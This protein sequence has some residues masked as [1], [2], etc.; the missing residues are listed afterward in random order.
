MYVGSHEKLRG[1]NDSLVVSG[2]YVLRHHVT[3]LLTLF[4]YTCLIYISKEILV[5]AI[6]RCLVHVSYL[7]GTRNVY[8]ARLS[9]LYDIIASL[10]RSIR[11]LTTFCYTELT[12]RI[13]SLIWSWVLARA[14][15]NDLTSLPQLRAFA[16]EIG[17]HAQMKT[18]KSTG[19]N[20]SRRVDYRNVLIRSVQSI[21]LCS[22]YGMRIVCR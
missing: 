22:T 13:S 5:G 4:T 21:S 20:L 8:E 14:N 12:R 15:I 18:H 10:Y 19:E 7:S 9:Q 6:V 16:N 3:L 11:I 1:L 17:V 2:R